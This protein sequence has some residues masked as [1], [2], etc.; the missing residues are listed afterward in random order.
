MNFRKAKAIEFHNAA[1]ALVCSGFEDAPDAGW[2]ADYRPP[3]V[4]V[5]NNGLPGLP[6]QVCFSPE[7]GSLGCGQGERVLELVA[8]IVGP[9]LLHVS[10]TLQIEADG[11]QSELR[12]AFTYSGSFTVWWLEAEPAP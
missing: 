6:W 5:R 3:D 7:A 12:A 11:R 9:H 1:A 2:R 8:C 4:S 10:L